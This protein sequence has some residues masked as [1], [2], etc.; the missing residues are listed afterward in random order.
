[1]LDQ[2]EIISSVSELGNESFIS[3][4]LDLVFWIL[5]SIN[6][7]AIAIAK[8]T[9]QS[10]I[11][12]LFSTAILNRQLLQK[13]QEEL[14]LGSTSSIL[15]TLTYFNAIAVLATYIAFDG[16]GVVALILG[17]IFILGVLIKW[18]F[19]WFVSFL[20]ENRGGIAEHGMNHLI[21]YQVGGIIL[22]PILIIS[23]FFPANLYGI[24]VV[25]SIVIVGILILLREIQSLGR[26]FK[27]RISV[28]YIIL[29]LCTLEILPLVL[30][31]YA[32]V[33]DFNGLN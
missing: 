6:L 4:H 31:I 14:K 5:M 33:N 11:K 13:T 23:H 17:G 32:F 8:T 16:H 21:Y 3:R 7:L 15:L 25:S 9:N 19:M 26:A 29:Y 10:Y 28:L 20:S 22:T 27:A 24:I 2:V 30:L 18:L 12:V 1:V